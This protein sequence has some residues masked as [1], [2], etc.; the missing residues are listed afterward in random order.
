MTTQAC[1][2][3]ECPPGCRGA[4]KGKA[5]LCKVRLG[6]STKLGVVAGPVYV[7]CGRCEVASVKQRTTFACAGLAHA[8]AV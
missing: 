3:F 2:L 1:G 4:G 5:S 7:W 6:G 8:F